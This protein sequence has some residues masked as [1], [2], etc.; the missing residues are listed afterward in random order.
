MD[1]LSQGFVRIANGCR[2]GVCGNFSK[3]GVISEVSGINI[4]IAGEFIG[5]ARSVF[6]ECSGG[7]ILIAGPPGSGKTTILRDLIRFFSNSGKRVSVIDPRGEI[8]ALYSGRPSFDLGTNT[9]TY[10]T[11]DKSFG[12]TAALR[13]MFPNIIAFDEIGTSSELSGVSEGFNAGVDIITTA[14]I[15]SADEIKKRKTVRE[16]L[17]SGAINNLFLLSGKIGEKPQKIDIKEVPL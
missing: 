2:A 3:D 6:E 10:I 17:L 13:T 7:G 12:I 8:S 1:E 11:Q 16:L 4:R 5:C 14:H 9:D 15:G